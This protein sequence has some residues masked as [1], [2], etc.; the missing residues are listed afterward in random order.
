MTDATPIAGLFLGLAGSAHCIAM[1]GGIASALDC[2]ARDGG[3]KA[4]GSHLL[5]AVG[6]IGSYALLGAVVGGLGHAMGAG[7]PP[8]FR[9]G[10]RWAVGLLLIALGIALAGFGPLRRIERLGMSVWRRLQPFSRTLSSLPG[11]IRMLGLGALWGFLPCGLVYG[12]VGVAAL[13]GNAAWSAIFMAAFGLGTLPAVLFMGLLA[14]GAWQRLRSANLR[15]ASAFAVMLCGVW[16]IVGPALT[17]AS[18]GAHH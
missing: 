12:A 6:R 1:C 3:W 10:T 18:A 11:P 17:R 14:S 8:E 7:L 5:Y 15:R 13:T 16:T 2:A 9:V 4:I